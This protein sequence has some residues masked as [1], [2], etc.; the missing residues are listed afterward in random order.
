MFYLLFDSQ[1]D[2]SVVS[3]GT[4][5]CFGQVFGCGFAA[6]LAERLCLSGA[7]ERLCGYAAEAEPHLKS[8][9][10]GKPK[11]FRKDSGKA[12]H[13]V[14]L[15][16]ALLRCVTVVIEALFS[17]QRHGDTETHREKLLLVSQRHQWIHLRCSS[18]R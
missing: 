6:I 15:L 10:N 2:D 12:A 13:P 14:R 17:P 7:T 4:T 9:I 1:I 18:R 11:A 3:K 5:S 8:Q 16:A